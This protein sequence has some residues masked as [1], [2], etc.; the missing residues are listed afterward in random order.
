M[1]KQ[2]KKKLIGVGLLIYCVA[3]FIQQ[4]NAQQVF[5]IT[6]GAAQPFVDPEHNGFYDLFVKALFNRLGLQVRLIPLPSERALINANKGIDD[7]NIARVKSISSFYPDLIVVPEAV[8]RF[9]FIAIANQPLAGVQHWSDLKDYNIAYINGW[10]IFDKKAKKYKSRIKVANKEQLF[11][12]LKRQRTD[13]VL[14]DQWGALWWQ[15]H[16]PG[17]RYF[18]SQPLLSKNLYLVLHK[19]H[20]SRVAQVEQTIRQ[21]KQEGEFQLIWQQT[22]GN[23]LPQEQKDEK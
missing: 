16:N 18:F 17:K 5:T 6:T 8:V 10:K 1:I 23:L 7:G 12:L 13:L 15:K 9:D 2:G 3:A 19:K 21:M 11:T 20:K 4:A 22:L 14:F